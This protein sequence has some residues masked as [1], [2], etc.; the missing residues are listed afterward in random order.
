MS[1][2]GNL[3]SVPFSDL[4]QLVF[5]GKKTGLLQ[6]KRQTQEK[7]IYFIE[8]NIVLA[9][10]GGNQEELLGRSFLKKS[11]ISESDFEKALSLYKTKKKKLSQTFLES[12][13][14]NQFELVEAIKL[15]ME[16]TI[17]SIFGWSEGEFQF[18]DGRLPDKDQLVTELNTMNVMMEGARRIDELTQIQMNL[19]PDDVAL[20][21][22]PYPP[23]LNDQ[24]RLD[25]IELSS[26]ELQILLLVDGE[27]TL[28]DI[29]ES[30][31]L[32]EFGTY[33]SLYR[34]LTD[35]FILIGERK[36]TILQKKKEQ[37]VL[38]DTIYEIFATPFFL[39]EEVMER[40][41]GKSKERIFEQSFVSK[42]AFY[43]VLA[44]LIP[45]GTFNRKNFLKACFSI[46][47]ETRLHQILDGL[48]ALLLTHLKKVSGFLG[49]N[50]V[51]EI[52]SQIKRKTA[53]I[54]AQN[55]EMVKKYRIDQDFYRTL[56]EVY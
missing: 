43:P 1:F 15:Q 30:S 55:R 41:L 50:I 16:E 13:K 48:E 52:I 18:L 17:Y 25:K 35:K 23:I 32:G 11:R 12:G 38:F 22:N 21:I 3:K 31:S 20:R 5:T 8:G 42:K 28:P 39:I 33:N 6:L 53:P 10:S 34:L 37:E 49:G 29:V 2:T 47:K 24:T 45:E 9:S 54:F 7:K 27:K 36:K 14:L 19:P 40:K 4:L 51:K 44:D 46:P 26:E 56:R